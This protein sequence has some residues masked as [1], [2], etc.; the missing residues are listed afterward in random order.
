ML[1][2]GV[3][4][5]QLT[6]KLHQS[7]FL[8]SEALRIAY[9]TAK[10]FWQAFMQISKALRVQVSFLTELRNS[11]SAKYRRTVLYYLYNFLF[12]QKCKEARGSFHLI[13]EAFRRMPVILAKHF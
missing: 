2:T 4:V 9:L 13:S 3:A 11:H 10:D 5:A 12:Q 7:I 6:S 8:Y 1:L